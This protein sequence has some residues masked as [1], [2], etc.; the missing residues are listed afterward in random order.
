[1]KI[2]IAGGT[3]FV[4]TALIKELVKE[5]HELFILTRHPEKYKKQAHL[6]Y[7]GWLYDGATPEKELADLDGFINLA[8]ESLNGGRWTPEQSDAL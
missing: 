4:G 3:G 2:A 6:S 7:I 5:N 1:M 8:G